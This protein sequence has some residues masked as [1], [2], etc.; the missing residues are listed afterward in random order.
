MSDELR[1]SDA[2]RETA[3]QALGEHFATGR[4]DAD[5]HAERHERIWGAR[6]RGE[7]APIF[8]D[9]PGGSPLHVRPAW[10]AAPP[11]SAYAPHTP[12]PPRPARR[13][14]LP[15]PLKALLAVAVVMLVVTQW[16]LLLVGLGVWWLVSS[17]RP[18]GCGSRAPRHFSHG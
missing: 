13:G 8:A 18:G 2:E 5:E 6:T 11:R 12:F 9:L 16:P 3:S 14:G 1:L 15:W 17:K 7:I 10:S 4:L